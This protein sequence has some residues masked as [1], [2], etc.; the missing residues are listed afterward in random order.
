MSKYKISRAINGISINGNEYV[1]NTD[2]QI[3][4]F[5]SVDNCLSFL[6]KHGI[7]AENTTEL[8]KKYNISIDEVN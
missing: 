8:Y 3:K 6:S 5:I 7:Y 4:L 1:L 2:N